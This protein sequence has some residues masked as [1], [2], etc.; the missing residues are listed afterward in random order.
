MQDAE[1]RSP[2]GSGGDSATALATFAGGCFWCMEP[3]FEKLDGVTEVLSGYA[4]GKEKDPTYKEVSSGK[5]GHAEVVRVRYNPKKVSYRRLLEVFWR[6]I[7]PTDAGGQFA[8]RGSQYRSAI[9]YHGEVQRRLAETTKAELRRSGRFDRPLVTEIVAAGPFFRAEEYHQDFYKKSP[10]RYRSYRSGSGREAFLERVWGAEAPP[11][12]AYD[13]PSD[14]ELKKRLT[15][16]Q[17][18]V[19]QKDGT[20]PPFKNEHWDNK[21]EGIYVDVVSGEPLFAS[22]DKYKSGTGWPSFTRP[23]EPDN[24]VNRVDRKLGYP[25]TEVR[26][27][28][29]DSHLGHL[30]PDGPKPTGQR[31]CINSAALRFVPKELLEKKGYGQYLHLFRETAVKAK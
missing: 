11:K 28:H 24:I 16:L 2:A 7:D 30:F 10:R 5:T 19:T 25:R 17:F 20:E 29:A 26:S 3:P 21:R 18:K 12:K 9:F 22:T 27:R 6:Q 14:A 4:G 15:A 31:Y 23:L 8:D 13:R 1:G